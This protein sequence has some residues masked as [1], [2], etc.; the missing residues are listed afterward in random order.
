MPGLTSSERFPSRSMT[1][2]N[3]TSGTSRTTRPHRPTDLRNSDKT[4]DSG[5]HDRPIP[6]EL[7]VHNLEHGG[8]LL[9]YPCA[10]PATIEV[11]ER[12]SRA[13]RP[14]QNRLSGSRYPRSLPGPHGGDC[15]NR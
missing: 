14:S 3:L 9:E 12:G 6:D 5:V 4:P 8:V 13:L 15:A 2:S 7:Q 11:L 1:T 10:R